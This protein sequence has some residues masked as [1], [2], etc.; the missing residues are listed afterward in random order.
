VTH[1]ESELA[2][3][4]ERLTTTITPVSATEAT[5]APRNHRAR[6][7]RTVATACAVAFVAA[8]TVTVTAIRI[9]RSDPRPNLIVP[10]LPSDPPTTLAGT[11]GATTTTTSTA[12][13]SAQPPQGA[14]VTIE[15]LGP[16][17]ID[18]AINRPVDQRVAIANAREAVTGRCMAEAGF[19]YHPRTAATDEKTFAEMI[20]AHRY[21][22]VDA[23]SA[24][25]LGNGTAHDLM[26]T[27]PSDTTPDAGLPADPA[28]R[29]AYLAA[30]NGMPISA[31]PIGTTSYRVTSGGCQQAASDAIFGSY[32][33]QTAQFNDIQAL[34]NTAG[35][36]V[37][38]SQAYAA[39]NQQWSTCMT[40]NGYVYA[41]PG[42][43]HQDWFFKRSAQPDPSTATPTEK[44][45]AVADATC[46]ATVGYT[47]GLDSLYAAAEQPLANAHS[48]EI[49]D[50]VQRF[51]DA[52][53][54]AGILLSTTDPSP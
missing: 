2:A 46:K 27:L 7:R 37:T 15:A 44:A 40:S 32:D 54:Q 42:S 21:G 28:V 30:L 47:A 1:V 12:T 25:M 23:D 17:P 36:A 19:D 43:A 41:D 8:I 31:V 48:T 38:A 35:A 26:I 34:S 5:M 24:A 11:I 22:I 10:A 49:I 9:S 52:A 14:V 51:T 3:Y 6:T 45:V 39:L 4:G 53:T 20:L 18:A 16:L 50:Y 13:T 33:T 29:D